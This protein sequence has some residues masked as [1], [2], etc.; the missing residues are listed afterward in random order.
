MSITYS[1]ARNPVWVNAEQTMIDLEVDFDHLDED[2]VSF[3]A[4][5]SGD[6]PHTH[7]LYARAVAGDFGTI[8]AYVDPDDGA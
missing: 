1:A 2:W 3:T 8:A 4:V 6:L 7:D 5:A